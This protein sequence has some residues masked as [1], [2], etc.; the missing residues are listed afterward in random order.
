MAIFMPEVLEKENR[1]QSE[2]KAKALG[3][4]FISMFKSL[5]TVTKQKKLSFIYIIQLAVA[6]LEYTVTAFW[7]ILISEVKG[8]PY[9]TV[10]QIAWITSGVLIFFK[11]Y[12]GK[13]ID[14][15]GY[16]GPIFIT[17]SISTT[18]LVLFL[19]VNSLPWLIV[20]YM[21]YS[22]SSLT[23]YIGVNAG[24]TREAI[25]TQRGMALGALG[26]YVSLSRSVSTLSFIPLS[27]NSN[28]VNGTIDWTSVISKIF[29]TTAIIVISIVSITYLIYYLIERRNGLK[30]NKL[31]AEQ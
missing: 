22:A 16:K 18:M 4:S 5:F 21:I 14:R 17:L 15:L 12:L 10:A 9:D 19:F 24:T 25:L 13:L 23:S 3:N 20:I 2:S 26:F 11:P 8:L 30:E 27:V 6:F 31:K 28:D 1:L 29:I 7:P